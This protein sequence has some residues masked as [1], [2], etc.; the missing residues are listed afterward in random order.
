[1]FTKYLIAFLLTGLSLQAI[2]QPGGNGKPNESF[3]DSL[4][5]IVKNTSDGFANYRYNE[6]ADGAAMIYNTTLPIPG[7]DQKLVQTG[8]VKAYKQSATVVVPCFVAAKN[9]TDL[10]AAYQF[11]TNTKKRLQNCLRPTA[12]DSLL[13]PGFTRNTSFLLRNPEKDGL[14]TAEIIL[15]S[16]KDS[17]TVFFRVF[18]NKASLQKGNMKTVPV[19]TNPVVTTPAKEPTKDPVKDPVTNPVVTN[20]VVTNPVA[21]NSDKNHYEEMLP[22]IQ[23]LI[24]YAPN[25]FIAIRERKLT[26]QNWEN[27]FT[28]TLS[29]KKF[30]NPVIEYITDNFWNRYNTRMFFNNETAA[31]QEYNKIVAQ[32][33][34]CST[35]I[36]IQQYDTRYS[37]ATDKSWYYQTGKRD[38]DGKFYK[39]ILNLSVSKATTGDGYY[40][41]LLFSKKEG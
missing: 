23:A 9:F 32:V 18:N 40:I 35:T 27:T 10:I 21:T 29:Y 7:F 3:C 15:M 33:Q 5:L 1:M 8:P 39:G 30:T 34:S 2:A 16:D 36:S 41:N 38:S 28:S 4:Q 24:Q 17:Q 37:T 25:N 11:Y 14:I 12:Q 19:I 20:P 6:R 26:N 22:F 13:K 31:L